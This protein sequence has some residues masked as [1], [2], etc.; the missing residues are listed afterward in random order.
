MAFKTFITIRTQCGF[1]ALN[2]AKVIELL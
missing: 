1:S 2:H